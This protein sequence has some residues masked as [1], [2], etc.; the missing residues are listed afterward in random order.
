MNTQ[1]H[2]PGIY[3]F[4]GFSQNVRA[5][6]S[7]KPFTRE[8]RSLFFEKAGF[9][10]C[11]LALVHQVHGDHVLCITEDLIPSADTQAD[12]LLTNGSHIVLGIKT[13]DCLP[14]LFED[15]EKGVIGAIHAGWRG[16]K[17]GILEKAV[18][19]MSRVYGTVPGNVRAAIGPAI[20]GCCYE[21]GP[22]F[23]DFFPDYYR[24]G[25]QSGDSAEGGMFDPIGAAIDRLHK[26]GISPQNIADSGFCT[27][28]RQDLFHSFRAHKTEE[29]MLSMIARGMS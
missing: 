9:T 7:G 6:F 5:V 22:E 4:N 29:R 27:V 25:R 3:S 10:G 16:L 12:G 18:A 13:A 19:K 17:A 15:P 11:S 14:V 24:S 23:K 26:A 20:R 21:V 28:C 8:D 1:M 2:E